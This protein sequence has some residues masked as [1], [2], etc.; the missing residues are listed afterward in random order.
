MF[1]SY[2]LLKWMHFVALSLI[3]GG[4]VVALLISGF[5]D[6][7]EDLRGL[8]ATLWKRTVCWGVRIAILLGAALLTMKFMNGQ[9]PFTENYLHLKLTFV[10]ILAGLTEATPKALAIG[11]RGSA[12]LALMLFLLASFTVYNKAI[13]GMKLHPI[14]P[15]PVA[16]AAP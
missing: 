3:G 15:T 1:D 8:A 2:S 12:L 7:R 11:K 14:P 13:F 10:V 4:A 6:E 5:E 9:H 16:S